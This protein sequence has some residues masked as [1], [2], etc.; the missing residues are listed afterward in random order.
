MDPPVYR[1]QAGKGIFDQLKLQL[2][3][4]GASQEQVSLWGQHIALVDAPVHLSVFGD[5]DSKSI[6]AY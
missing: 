2:E 6:L 3:A 4:Q 1:I 5:E